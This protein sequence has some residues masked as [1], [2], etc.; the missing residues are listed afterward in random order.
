MKKG[1]HPQVYNDAVVTCACGNSFVTMSTKKE[2]LVKF[3][4]LVILSTPDKKDILTRKVRLKSLPKKLRWQESE[5]A[6]K[7]AKAK[8]QLKRPLPPS[9]NLSP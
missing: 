5:T 9:K 7:A 8:K 4:L 3:V 6:N 1:I 2:I